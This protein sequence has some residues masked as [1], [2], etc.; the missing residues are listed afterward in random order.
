VEGRPSHV[1]RDPLGCGPLMASFVSP[2]GYS[3]GGR[4]ER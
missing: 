2:G 1:D 3:Q 4:R